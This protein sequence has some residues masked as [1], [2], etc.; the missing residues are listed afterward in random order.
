MSVRRGPPT[1]HP[2]PARILPQFVWA[3]HVGHCGRRLM[4]DRTGT[5]KIHRYSSCAVEMWR[6]WLGCGQLLDQP[7]D[8][9]RSSIDRQTLR[10]STAVKRGEWSNQFSQSWNR[11]PRSTSHRNCTRFHR[12]YFIYTL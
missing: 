1:M 3:L 10:Q 5:W 4:T 11:R 2:I 8:S 12:L 6:W 9:C 7:S